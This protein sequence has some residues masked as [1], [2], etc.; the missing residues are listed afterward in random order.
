MNLKGK[1]VF[2]VLFGRS[3]ADLAARRT[4]AFQNLSP[5]PDRKKTKDLGELGRGLAPG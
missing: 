3:G 4:F 1:E 2:S 5:A